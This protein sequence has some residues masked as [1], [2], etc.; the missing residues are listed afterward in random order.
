MTAF[1]EKSVAKFCPPSSDAAIPSN[2]NV[3]SGNPRPNLSTWIYF[4][5]DQLRIMKAFFQ[6]KQY[7]NNKEATKLA[8]ETNL[9]R[10]ILYV[11]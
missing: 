11:S 7:L 8:Q 10:K 9:D 2:N 6:N 1:V 5:P 3:E 4:K